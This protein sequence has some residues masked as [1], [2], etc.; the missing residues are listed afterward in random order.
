MRTP[1]NS[2]FP[3]EERVKSSGRKFLDS[4]LSCYFSDTGCGS[5]SHSPCLFCA[6]LYLDIWYKMSLLQYLFW[7][8]T[9][10]QEWS[11]SIV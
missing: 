4:I 10:C 2:S 5:M 8:Y 9:C 1:D 11:H 3:K 6:L 7:L